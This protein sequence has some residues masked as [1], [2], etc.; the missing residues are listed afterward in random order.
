MTISIL[1]IQINN[2]VYNIHDGIVTKIAISVN[3]Q[4]IHL[5][6][7][8]LLALILI[9]WIQSKERDISVTDNCIQMSSWWLFGFTYWNCYE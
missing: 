6:E 2:Y 3:F 7:V 5:I 1:V 8:I 9:P 4:R